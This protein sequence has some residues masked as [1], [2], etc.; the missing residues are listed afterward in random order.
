LA[1]VSGEVERM[2]APGT[3][4][5]DG[6]VNFFGMVI[7]GAICIVVAASPAGRSP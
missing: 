4:H 7:I 5:I 3:R 6:S 1:V 2:I